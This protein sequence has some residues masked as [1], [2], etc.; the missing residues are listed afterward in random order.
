MRLRKQVLSAQHRRRSALQVEGV[1]FLGVSA[2]TRATGF[3][4][5]TL[6]QRRR[7]GANPGEI[8]VSIRGER[9]P[10]ILEDRDRTRDLGIGTAV[11]VD[12]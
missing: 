11:V 12:G 2:G 10:V 4:L 7:A 9:R 6:G 5:D 1:V 8:Q 3:D